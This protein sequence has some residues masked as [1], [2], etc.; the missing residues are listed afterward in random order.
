LEMAGKRLELLHK[1]VPAAD[2]MIYAP[3]TPGRKRFQGCRVQTFEVG[4]RRSAS[5]K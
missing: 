5:V 2:P 3:A 1:L 4:P